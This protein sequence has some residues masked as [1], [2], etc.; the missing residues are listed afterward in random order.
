MFWIGQQPDAK[1]GVA[2]FLEKRPARFQMKPSRDLPQ[3]FPLGLQKNL[4]GGQ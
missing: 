2:S 4:S 3:F 1:E